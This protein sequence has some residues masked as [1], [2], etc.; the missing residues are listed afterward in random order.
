MGL[1]SDLLLLPVTGPA[2]GLLFIAEQLKEQVDAELLS[3]SSQIQDELMNLAM[4]YELGEISE[5]AYAEEEDA[6]LARLNEIRN[7]G[8]EEYWETEEVESEVGVGES[9]IESESVEYT[10]EP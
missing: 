10:D 5:Q 7:D 6:L 8:E 2:R 9:P 4:R 3:E 1:L